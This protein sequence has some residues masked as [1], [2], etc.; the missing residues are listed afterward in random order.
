MEP[1]QFEDQLDQLAMAPSI[2]DIWDEWTE[3]ANQVI[4]DGYTE[5]DCLGA[6]DFNF[7]NDDITDNSIQCTMMY[8]SDKLSVANCYALDHWIRRCLNKPPRR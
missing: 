7:N 3:I 2:A 1:D 5:Y 6:M 4:P 8:Y